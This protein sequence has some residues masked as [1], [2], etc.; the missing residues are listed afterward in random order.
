MLEWA[1]ARNADGGREGC[2]DNA[3]VS[4]FNIRHQGWKG[5]AKVCENGSR[6]RLADCKRWAGAAL[7]GRREVLRLARAGARQTKIG[8]IWDLNH[9]K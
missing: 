9:K 8:N 4:L 2:G 6:R 5:K 1:R 7:G 3:M